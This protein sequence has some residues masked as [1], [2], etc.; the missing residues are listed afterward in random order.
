SAGSGVA[1]FS[2]ALKSGSSGCSL[3][4]EFPELAFPLVAAFFNDFDF[5]KS[6]AAFSD[7]CKPV[8]KPVIERALK[9]ARRAPRTIQASLIA[10]LEAWH[11]AGL[12]KRT[13]DAS[14][15]GLIVAGQNL[16]QCY[17]YKL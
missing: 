2:E 14:R 13:I 9:A 8:P 15:I 16:N 10:A 17:R 7:L 6:L 12:S 3:G 11:M 4:T 1:S 5:E